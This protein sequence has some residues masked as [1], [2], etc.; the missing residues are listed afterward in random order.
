MNIGMGDILPPP[1]KTE[2]D[3]DVMDL[4]SRIKLQEE[5]DL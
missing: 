3:S 4:N 1:V 2:E 5:M